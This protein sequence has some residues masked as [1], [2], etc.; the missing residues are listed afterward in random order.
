MEMARVENVFELELVTRPGV[1]DEMAERAR[2]EAHG[3]PLQAHAEPRQSIHDDGPHILGASCERGKL[4]RRSPSRLREMGIELAGVDELFERHRQ[5]DQERDIEGRVAF[6][7]G[8]R[9]ASADARNRCA[10]GAS[11]AML[12][13]RSEPPCAR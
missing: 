8:S 3:A 7:S 1:L 5:R 13:T 12:R 4:D 9:V 6:C 2:I 11:A 10:S